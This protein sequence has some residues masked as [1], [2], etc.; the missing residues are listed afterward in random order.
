M[1]DGGRAMNASFPSR[2]LS[3][4]PATTRSANGGP[5]RPRI[6]DAFLAYEQRV[7]VQTNQLFWWLLLAQWVFAILV[8]V[9]WSPQTW[10]GAESALHPHLIAAV[11]LGAL[12]V[13]P[14]LLLIR[15]APHQ[16]VTRHV[17]AVAQVSFSA[18]LIHL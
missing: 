16:W 11:V 9:I 7:F 12:L 4:I 17:V 15:R 5:P 2:T 8:A 13:L 1:Q 14:P 10:E 3:P 6:D 18:L